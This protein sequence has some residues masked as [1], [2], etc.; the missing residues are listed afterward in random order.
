MTEGEV[1]DALLACGFKGL[2]SLPEGTECFNELECFMA[3]SDVPEGYDWKKAPGGARF[4]VPYE[5]FFRCTGSPTDE[6]R[7]D[8]KRLSF[9]VDGAGWD[10]RDEDSYVLVRLGDFVPVDHCFRGR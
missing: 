4:R 10:L 7:G 5:S 1:V 8:G 6:Q 2:W 9:K 3:L